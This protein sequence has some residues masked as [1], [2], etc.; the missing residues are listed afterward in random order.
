[1][2]TPI[3]SLLPNSSL[4]PSPVPQPLENSASF[5][6]IQIFL[7]SGFLLINILTLP[8]FKKTFQSFLKEKLCKTTLPV[9]QR[10]LQLLLT[11]WTHLF[12]LPNLLGKNKSTSTISL[13]QLPFSFIHRILASS[14]I[15]I[16]ILILTMSHMI[17]L[18]FSRTDCTWHYSIT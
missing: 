15:P 6:Y 18:L 10:G 11:F 1:M 8:I 17:L 4:F 14:P 3:K 2:A 5:L 7:F 9:C 12:S 16:L 13:L